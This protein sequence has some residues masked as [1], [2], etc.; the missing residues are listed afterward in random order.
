MTNKT[1]LQGIG[2]AVA[3]YTLWGL[4]PVYWKA[5]NGATATEILAHRM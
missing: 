4:L 2:A 5:L 3:A 1:V